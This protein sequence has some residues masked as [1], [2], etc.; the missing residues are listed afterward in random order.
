MNTIH[1][2]KQG[3]CI[4][5]ILALSFLGVCYDAGANAADDPFKN[6]ARHEKEGQFF[7][8]A[9]SY[10]RVLR[11]KPGD[12]KARTALARVGDRAIAEK[13]SIATA[14]EAE[15]KL[16]EAVAAIESARR[17]QDQMLSLKIGPDQ[18]G[19]IDSRREQLVMRRVETLLAEA[20]RAQADGLW[21]AAVAHLQQIDA[22]VPD[23]NDTRKRLHDVWVAWGE[24]NLGEGRLR[25]A[26]ERF[27]QASRVPGWLSG[28]SASRAATIRAGLGSSELAR[29]ACRGALVDL[30]A[31]ERLAPGSVQPDVL[32]QATECAGT[33]VQLKVVADPESGLG[34]G[35]LDLL[36]AEVRKQ[37]GAGASEFLQIRGSG[38]NDARGCTSRTMPGMDGQTMVVGPY[39]SAIRVTA[40]SMFRQTA[41]SS[42]HQ[43]RPQTGGPVDM[44]VTYEEYQ[45]PF[46]GTIS[47]WVI[48]TDRGSSGLSVPLPVKITRQTLAR[49]QR[50][51]ISSATVTDQYS[52]RTSSVVMIDGSNRGRAQAEE[53]RRRARAGLTETLILDF[54]AEAARL[55]LA[56]VDVEPAVPDP[57]ALPNVPAS[58]AGPSLR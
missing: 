35:Q 58:G 6:G 48:V 54:A 3:L 39:Q 21:S 51:P 4:L 56:T 8:A 26:A 15:L 52:G 19:M 14:L 50:N 55:L 43:T 42:T 36:G 24:T 31:A 46:V 32:N 57:T 17:L 40:I 22:L 7:Q 13:L 9:E 12:Q 1:G 33:C 45:E 37:I 41:S 5:A 29:G 47:G 27:D 34:D 20:D 11:L 18:H 25:A 38:A 16:D 30:R 23:F 2:T 10:A 44:V 28:S 49:W 53:E